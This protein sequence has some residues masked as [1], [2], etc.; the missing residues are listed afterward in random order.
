MKPQ[1]VVKIILLSSSI[2]ACFAQKIAGQEQPPSRA[3]EVRE[4]SADQARYDIDF[5]PPAQ[6]GALSLAQAEPA[7]IATDPRS[8]VVFRGLMTLDEASEQDLSL[9]T[10]E[11]Q[12]RLSEDPVSA[13]QSVDS[14]CSLEDGQPGK[15]GTFELQVQTGWQTTSGEHDPF[16]LLNELQYNP[17]G[18]EFLR[19]MQLTLGVP[20]EMGLG[21][22]D[23][24]ADLE[25][26]WQQR[27]IKENGNMPTIATYAQMR[28]PSG[29]HS[30][31]VD[32]TLTGIVAKDV[33]PG[34][35]YLNAFATTVNG[36]NIEDVRHFQWG[37]RGGYKWRISEEWAFITDY[38]HQSSEEEGHANSNE[39][40]L[41]GEWHVNEHLTIGPGII[42]GLDDNEETPN[43]GAGL[44]MMIS[45]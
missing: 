21:G 43:F 19:N 45:F 18:S 25:F 11:T 6:P 36:D 10:S 29:Y 3:K 37:F 26:G 14:F 39:L 41:S 9:E 44:R 23:G 20:V 16:T 32:G 31:G 8:D 13:R 15:P 7:P 30:S 33:G 28:I 40:E 27:W 34:T 35:M 24:N 2:S 5:T 42:I 1:A 38:V 17:E 12:T 22:V 4:D